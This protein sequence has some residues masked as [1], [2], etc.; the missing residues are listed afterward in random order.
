M[1]VMCR[2]C[3]GMGF[4]LQQHGM[5]VGMYCDNCGAWLKWVG[6]KDIESFKRKGVKV[7]VKNKFI[8]EKI[9]KRK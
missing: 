9:C 4:F 1:N 2:K 3:S 8:D 5:Q 7:S 6:K